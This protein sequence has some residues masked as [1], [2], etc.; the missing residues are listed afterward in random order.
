MRLWLL[1][2]LSNIAFAQSST[3]ILKGGAHAGGAFL[4]NG[5]VLTV[6]ILPP[7]PPANNPANDPY[8]R[9]AITAHA[10]G[11]QTAWTSA[12]WTTYAP[13][14]NALDYSGYV[15]SAPTSGTYASIM[16]A[17]AA[18]SPNPTPPR[19]GFYIQ[20]CCEWTGSGTDA[21]DGW[22]NWQEIIANNNWYV[23]T[24]WPSGS[25]VTYTGESNL[26]YLLFNPNNSTPDSN[27]RTIAQEFAYHFDEY[28]A[29]GGSVE[30]S[31][32][33]A[34]S[35]LGMYFF[36]NQWMKN[37]NPGT[38]C[39]PTDTTEYAVNAA[40]AAV[41]VQKGQAAVV[42]AFRAQHPGIVLWGNSGYWAYG[43]VE[44]KTVVLNSSNAALFDYALAE[45]AEEYMPYYSA[46]TL[47][48]ML[49][50]G[51]AVVASTGSQVISNYF[52]GTGGNGIIWTGAQSTW[53]ATLW[54]VSRAWN[55]LS[56][57]R[58]WVWSPNPYYSTN[59]LPW[60]DEDYQPCVSGVHGWLSNGSQRLDPPQTGPWSNGVYRRRFPNGWVLW[61]PYG[62]GVQ[63][64]S[65]PTTLYRIQ[66]CSSSTGTSAVNTG[67]QVTS[68]TVTLQDGG[69]GDGLFLIGTG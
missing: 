55:A 35:T 1:L 22:V 68:G 65:V 18:A 67:A 33:A 29:L 39:A 47:F 24:S 49:E 58:N 45:G 50:Q 51:E 17:V 26:G 25:I 9:I 54:Q 8:P 11:V 43:P 28:W 52:T 4:A 40:N 16:A 63:T 57:M 15:G 64:V 36:D 31:H 60:F 46:T 14:Y 53:S 5:K 6:P 62:N 44:N 7:I 2:L 19:Q 48:Q 41:C 66:N 27:G 3:F 32:I 56:Q 30:S 12:N 38:F 13:L 59:V 61:N 10:G 34:N 69:N 37:V 42:A 20:G 23:R 21:T